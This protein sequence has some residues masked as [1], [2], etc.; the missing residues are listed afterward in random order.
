IVFNLLTDRGHSVD[1]VADGNAVLRRVARTTYDV[2]LMDIQMPKLDGLRT[3]ELIREQERRSEKARHLPVFALTAQAMDGVE[4]RC[5]QVGMDGYL[6]K[7]VDQ[8][9]LYRVVEN[10]DL[11]VAEGMFR[12]VNAR[13]STTV[14]ELGEA[15]EL[16]EP[17]GTQSSIDL[18]N[19][20][21]S[22]P[23]Q[24]HEIEFDPEL[25]SRNT[26]GNSTTIRQMVELFQ[27]ES[28][29]QFSELTLA[30]AEGELTH[31]SQARHKLKGTLGIFGASRAIE[32]L[33]RC[34]EI[35][36]AGETA[37][38]RL[39]ELESELIRLGDA[40]DRWYADQA[41]ST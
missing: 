13:H 31:A 36:S 40:L 28:A 2:V 22:A 7:P 23:S 8:E 37:S 5:I 32:A 18:S 27:T 4:D 11:I 39:G 35:D 19:E 10:C 38:Q 15:T 1:V 20:V 6:S 21:T 33:H 29:K 12:Q 3:T 14:D 25:F 41:E 17:S 26:G 34:S 9:E 30:I 16:R 24:S